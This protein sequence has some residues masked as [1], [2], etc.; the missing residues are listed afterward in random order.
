AVPRP[1]WSV[2]EETALVSGWLNTS[3]D[4]IIGKEQKAGRFWDRV[5]DYVAASHATADLP[6]REANTCSQSTSCKRSRVEEDGTTERPMGVKAAKA[7]A[8]KEK[9]KKRCK[10]KSEETDD[11]ERVKMLE[12]E[13]MSHK[14]ED[15]KGRMSGRRCVLVK[16]HGY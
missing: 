9:G 10:G 5:A 6:R 8:A 11:S 3:K 16:S 15:A 12:Q 4:P 13:L 7:Q 2:E 1:R 14:G